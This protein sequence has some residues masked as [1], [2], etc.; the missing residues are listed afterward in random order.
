MTFLYNA[1]LPFETA[2]LLLVVILAAWDWRR[3]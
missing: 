2:F 3:R 1:H